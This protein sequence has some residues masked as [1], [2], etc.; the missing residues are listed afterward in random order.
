VGTDGG[1]VLKWRG[2]VNCIA[3]VTD[4]IDSV[5]LGTHGERWVVRYR[6]PKSG[7]DDRFLAGLS[8]VE[9]RG[10]RR[11]NRETRRRVVESLL[12]GLVIPDEIPPL[13]DE[14]ADRLIVLADVSTRCRGS[15]LRGGGHHDEISQVLGAEETPRLTDALATLS[16][17]LSVLGVG[18]GW[19]WQLLVKCALDPVHPLRRRVIDALLESEDNLTTATVAGRCSLPQTSVRRHLENLTAHKLLEKAGDHPERWGLS[20][21]LREHWWATSGMEDGHG[22]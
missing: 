6:M 14:E 19:R 16:G 12:A 21:W 7:D 15:V 18:D 20:S 13:S 10:R 4:V 22:R 1:Q 2:A 17:A 9:N 5:D 11:A 3:C 8:A